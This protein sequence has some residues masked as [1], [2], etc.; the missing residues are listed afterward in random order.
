MGKMSCQ[1][2]ANMLWFVFRMAVCSIP[3]FH[4]GTLPRPS[5]WTINT[6][7]WYQ[8]TT[9][10]YPNQ[11]KG[12]RSDIRPAR[13]YCCPLKSLPDAILIAVL[14]DART[15]MVSSS[16]CM[17]SVYGISTFP[18]LLVGMF[19]DLRDNSSPLIIVSKAW[20]KTELSLHHP[21]WFF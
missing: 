21:F 16:C 9:D 19:V 18:S 14:I 1:G 20:S 2:S 6:F 10:L 17:P 11:R 4:F 7:H 3:P 5:T 13:L 8:Q 12:R 15:A